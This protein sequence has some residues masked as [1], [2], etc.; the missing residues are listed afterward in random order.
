MSRESG[1]TS[2]GLFFVV[3]VLLAVLKAAL[4]RYFAL[5]EANPLSAFLLETALIVIVLGVVDLIPSRRRYLLTLSAYGVLSFVMLAIT[6]YVAFYAQLFDPRMLSMAGQLGTVVGSISS[7]IKP[8]YLL[9]FIDIPFL[10]WW[11]VV[12]G[13]SDNQRIASVAAARSDGDAASRRTRSR[14]RSRSRVSSPGSQPLGRGCGDGGPASVRRAARTRRTDPERG[15]WRG[16]SATAR[17]GRGPG[18]GVPAAWRRGFGAGGHRRRGARP[19]RER[20]RDGH[21]R[22]G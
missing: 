1:R 7:L 9:F 3:L 8:A 4:M 19:R 10:A 11:A 22:R 20:R 17:N 14:R 2:G 13:R 21:S 6:V 16:G 12:L 15:R 5:D 18:V